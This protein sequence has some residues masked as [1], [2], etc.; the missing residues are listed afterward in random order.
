MMAARAS[1]MAP[2]LQD[3]GDDAAAVLHV[4]QGLTLT[5]NAAG[6][7]P[8]K[9]FPSHVHFFQPGQAGVYIIAGTDGFTSPSN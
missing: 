3:V 4:V 1:G 5:E 7:R 2:D 8:L 9:Q 6:R